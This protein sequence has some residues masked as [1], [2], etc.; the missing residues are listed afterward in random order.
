MI[1]HVSKGLATDREYK[2]KGKG[3]EED[4]LNILAVDNQLFLSEVAS[5][6]NIIYTHS[7]SQYVRLS[8]NY[9]KYQTARKVCPCKDGG[10]CL[11]S[12][13]CTL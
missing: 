2:G 11:H 12:V 7:L 6:G 5:A 8:T 4:Y 10:D 9:C 13:I 3:K 1:T